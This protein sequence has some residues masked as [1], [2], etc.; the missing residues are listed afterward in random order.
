MFQLVERVFRKFSVIA[1]TTTLFRK[2][3][4]MIQLVETVFREFSVTA[5]S[6]ALFRKFSFLLFLLPVCMRCRGEELN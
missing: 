5:C 4:M 1:Y 2:F 3:R 6:A